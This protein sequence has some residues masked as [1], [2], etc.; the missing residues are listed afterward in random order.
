MLIM[1]T[2]YDGCELFPDAHCVV[3][4]VLDISYDT[5]STIN[6]ISSVEQTKLWDDEIKETFL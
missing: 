2:V 4:M 5:S 6:S 3:S 1:L